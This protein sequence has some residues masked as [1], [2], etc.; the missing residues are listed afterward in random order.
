[1]KKRNLAI[2]IGDLPYRA[3]TLDSESL[4]N[5]F[6]G[7]D[8]IQDGGTCVCGSTCCTSGYVCNIAGGNGTCGAYTG[9]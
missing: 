7:G 4:S 6:G 5:I 8:C 3:H 2:K 1:M 9:G